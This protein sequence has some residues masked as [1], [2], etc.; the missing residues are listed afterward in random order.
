MTTEQKKS[1]RDAIDA[2]L[3]GEPVQWKLENGLAWS[4]ALPD[5]TFITDERRMVVEW[6]PKPKEPRKGYMWFQQPE[7]T[8]LEEAKSNAKKFGGFAIQWTEVLE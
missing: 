4:D 2:D 7:P 5:P 8:S 6:R 3:R 1:L